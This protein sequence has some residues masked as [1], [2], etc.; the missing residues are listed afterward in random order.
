MSGMKDVLGI[1]VGENETSK[2]WLKVLTEIRN[3]GVADIFIA[4]VDGLNGFSEAIKA[5]FPCTEIQRC[6]IHQIRN[7]GKYVSYKDIKQFNKDLKNVY[8]SVNEPAALAKFDRFEHKW[9][10][11]Y[12]IAIRS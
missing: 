10:S 3:R 9:G 1:W 11:K 4:S 12:S 6:I 8:T 5:V 2:Y 7:S